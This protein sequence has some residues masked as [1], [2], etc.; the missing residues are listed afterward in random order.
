MGRKT[1]SSIPP[2]F[3][4]L[5][6]RMN[7]VLTRNRLLD[8]PEDVLRAES[9]EKVLQM[10]KNEQLKNAMET[11]FVIGGQQIYEEVLKSGACEKLYVTHVH[12]DFEC[13]TFFPPF[14]DD[15]QS[16]GAS[17]EVVERGATFHF[18][19]YARKSAV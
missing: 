2:Q 6:G 14:L 8:L 16:I 19:E 5:A 13:D 1:W 18:E 11:I 3:H 15:F 12:G 4:P 7:I 9:F 10:A 17:E